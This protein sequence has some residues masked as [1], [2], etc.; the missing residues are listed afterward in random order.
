MT[1]RNLLDRVEAQLERIVE[2][3]FNKAAPFD[4]RELKRKLLLAL[5]DAGGSVL[6]DQWYVRLPAG[7]KAR[8]GEVRALVDSLWRSVLTATDRRDW[9]AGIPPA[10]HVEYQPELAVGSLMVGYT[11]SSAVRA[12]DRRLVPLPQ[13]VASGI[14]TAL[15][16]VVLLALTVALL[17][18]L[19]TRPGMPLENLAPLIPSVNIAATRYVTTVEVRVRSEPNTAAPSVGAVPAGQTVTLGGHNLVRGEKIGA[20]DRWVDITDVQ[21]WL[22]GNHRYIWFGALAAAPQGAR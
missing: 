7:L 21:G 13:R 4:V 18:V 16:K 6:P 12:V 20:E 1:R 19:L 15:A 11:V 22:T 3:P 5:R 10:I 14:A 2:L 17:G 9:P 8:D